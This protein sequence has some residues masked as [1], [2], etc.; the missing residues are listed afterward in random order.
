MIF[1]RLVRSGAAPGDRS[2][3]HARPVAACLR[4]RVI[5]TA[6]RPVDALVGAT[7]GRESRGVRRVGDD[8]A[9]AHRELRSLLRHR[10]RDA[11]RELRS[12]PQSRAGFVVGAT[13]GRESRGV[14]GVGDDGACAHRELRSLLRHRSRHVH[15][16]LRS[17][18]QSRAGFVVG[19][20]AGCDS[21]GVRGVGDDGACAHRELR[22][23]LRNRSRHAHR[24][25]R[26]LLRPRGSVVGA[27]A[28]REGGRR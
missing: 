10:S 16:E 15:R 20:T 25:L 3:G 12:L 11:H 4:D 13:A 28:G 19:A 1:R 14:R 9:C 23:L 2:N 26:S 27:T 22:S 8:G 5:A 6:G 21:G 18:L 24:E 17:L 7:A